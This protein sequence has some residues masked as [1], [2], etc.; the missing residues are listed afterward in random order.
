MKKILI[1]IQNHSLFFSYQR[2][3]TI[4]EDLMNTNII[5]DSELGFT[6]DYLQANKKIVLPFF[7]EL[8]SMNK[9]DTLVFQNVELAYFIIDFFKNTS[10]RTIKIKKQEAVSYSFCE[11]L[12]TLK[13]IKVLDC[14]TVANFILDFLDNHDI[15]VITHS[16]VLSL[17]P[18]MHQN[19]LQDYSTMYYKKN[20]ELYQKFTLDDQEDLISLLKINHY[21]KIIDFY[22]YD[23]EDLEFL[24]ENLKNYRLKNILIR[25]HFNIKN[26]EDIL[27]LKNLNKKYKKSKLVIELVYSKEYLEDNLMKQVCLNTLKLCGF[28]IVFFILGTVGYIFVQNYYA[29]QEVSSIQDDVASVIE[30]SE[31][32]NTDIPE[33]SEDGL[34]IKNKYIASLLTI[35]PDIVGYLKVNNTNIDYPVVAADDNKYYLKKNLY[36]QDDINGWIF[37]DF[38]NSDKNLNDNTIIYGHNMDDGSMFAALLGYRDLSFW[39][40]HRYIQFDTLT[41]EGRYEVLAAFYVDVALTDGGVEF[42]YYT[43]TDLRDPAVFNDYISHVEALALYDTGVAAEPGDD[44]LTLS[45]CSYHVDDGRFVVVAKR[46]A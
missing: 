17:S 3:Q 38:R 18:F 6:D 28:L 4:R 34:T 29:M 41:Q 10:I 40:E 14:F 15:K 36:Q 25:I 16:E 42:P 1:H 8:S 43:Y 19:N 32:D 22:Y 12:V 7:K 46:V 26:N 33:T 31:T 23:Q 9:I 24:L 37:M 20:L 5:S 30:K 13:N 27:Y 45:T 39:Q 44:L 2:K 11:K 21:L 35:N